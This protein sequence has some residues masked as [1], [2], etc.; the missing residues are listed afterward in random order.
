MPVSDQ[1][2]YRALTTAPSPP[3]WNE[4][5]LLRHSS[6]LS[7]TR[8]AAAVQEIDFRLDDELGLIIGT[9]EELFESGRRPLDSGDRAAGGSP[10][11]RS[12][13]DVLLDASRL[14]EIWSP[15]PL[16]TIAL[17]RLAL[18]V[19]HAAFVAG[20]HRRGPDAASLWLAAARGGGVPGALARTI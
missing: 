17:H 7:W 14:R 2:A 12:L 4:S 16:E 19:L 3:G 18:A 1:R 8:A 11:L 15:S 9:P 6:C 13:A 20:E 10:R 5:A